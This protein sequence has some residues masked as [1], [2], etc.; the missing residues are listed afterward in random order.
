MNNKV[1][2][3]LISRGIDTS[4]YFYKLLYEIEPEDSNDPVL[5]LLVNNGAITP[6]TKIQQH[7]ANED[8][9]DIISIYVPGVKSFQLTRKEWDEYQ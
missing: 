5:G 9:F 4:D 6:Q 2:Q 8:D 7:G 3:I 1:K